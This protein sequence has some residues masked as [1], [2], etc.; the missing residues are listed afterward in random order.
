MVVF[1]FSFFCFLIAFNSGEM[2]TVL[3]VAVLIS[4][5]LYLAIFHKIAEFSTSCLLNVKKKLSKYKKSK[6][7]QKK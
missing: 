2:R 3:L 6:K 7:V 4:F 1:A 5:L